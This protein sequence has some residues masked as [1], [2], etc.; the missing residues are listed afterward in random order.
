MTIRT[1]QFGAVRTITLNRPERRN[2][3]DIP[4]RLAL[5]DALEASDR[6][7][8]VRAIV[9]TGAGP[10]FCSGG[11]ITTMRRMSP[12]DALERAQLAQRVIRAIWNTPKP[13]IAAV[14]GGAFGAGLA[15]AAACDRVVA[16][17]DARFA[18]TFLNVGLAGDMGAYASLPARIG[19]ART[20]QMLLMG[21]PI[22]A[23]TALARGLVDD[24]ADPGHCLRSASDDAHTLANR[25]AQALG[26]IKK[27]L[28]QAPRLP[29][30]DVLDLEANQQAEL[31]GTDDFAEG[32]TAFR[33]K[34]TPRFAGR[35][36]LPQGV[37]S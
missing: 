7:A 37:P 25:P 18:T 4:L 31:F 26:V 30:T 5:A 2:A 6:D 34:R 8:S 22:D 15:L 35:E 23:D 32:V 9:L 24:L 17:K 19:V 36:D 27:L 10:M 13:V 3:I 28:A 12:T 33:E 1:E 14:E 29:A 11:D 20:R 16:A 21:R